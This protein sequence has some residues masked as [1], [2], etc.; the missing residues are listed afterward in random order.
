MFIFVNTI[1]NDLYFGKNTLIR[2]SLWS[3]ATCQKNSTKKS[4]FTVLAA[5]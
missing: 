1:K 3:S 2:F 4:P 5:V